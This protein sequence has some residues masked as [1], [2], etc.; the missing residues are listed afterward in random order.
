M[1]G[2]GIIPAAAAAIAAM[3]C[4]CAAVIAPGMAGD[5]PGTGAGTAPAAAPRDICSCHARAA[6]TGSRGGILGAMAASPGA[7]GV[8]FAAVEAGF[9]A[10]GLG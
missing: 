7:L 6:A 10:A 8:A 4:M 3:F 1:S 2:G 9:V 5:I